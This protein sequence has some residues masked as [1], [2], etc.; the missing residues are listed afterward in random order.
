MKKIGLTGGIGSG[1]S[2][3]CDVFAALGVAV[4]NSDKQ[5]KRIMNSNKELRQAIE[6]EFGEAVYVDGELDRGA[7]AGIVFGDSEKLEKLNKIV[8][9]AVLRDFDLW[10]EGQSS[11]YVILESAI[12]VESGFYQF[13]DVNICVCAPLAERIVRT[14]LRDDSSESEVTRRI[15]SQGDDALRVAHCHY[16]IDNAESDGVLAQVL[17][18]HKDLI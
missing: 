17:A 1:K 6:S 10:A 9:P 15:N 2:T 5:A 12:L 16:V 4:Y 3:V 14:M 7:M 13:M 11:P 8:H 18:I